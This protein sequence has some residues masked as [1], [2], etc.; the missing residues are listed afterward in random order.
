MRVVKRG[1]L[2]DASTAFL[3]TFWRIE[4]RPRIFAA[5]NRQAENNDASFR[6]G[7]E[8]AYGRAEAEANRNSNSRKKTLCG[9]SKNWRSR[10]K[11]PT[12]PGALSSP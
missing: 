8:G 5:T 12:L 3:K 7:V 9:G 4:L 10:R 1:A 11:T 2:P 6:G